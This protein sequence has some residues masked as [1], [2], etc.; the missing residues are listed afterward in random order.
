MTMLLGSARFSAVA[1]AGACQRAA[2]AFGLR[3]AGDGELG[4]AILGMSPVMRPDIRGS[5]L[6]ILGA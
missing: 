4:T 5:D 1:T 6:R 2:F 3:G